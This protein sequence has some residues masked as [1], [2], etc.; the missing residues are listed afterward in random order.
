MKN[1]LIAAIGIGILLLTGGCSGIGGIRS[2]DPPSP[3]A[4]P[5]TEEDA[6]EVETVRPPTPTADTAA[7]GMVA[8]YKGDCYTETAY[9][10]SGKPLIIKSEWRTDEPSKAVLVPRASAWQ[11]SQAFCST[12]VGKPVSNTEALTLHQGE[13]VVEVHLGE[14]NHETGYDKDGNHIVIRSTWVKDNPEN[15]TM[16][17][18]GD[19]WMYSQAFCNTLVGRHIPRS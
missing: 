9:D 6:V 16:A 19:A 14:C 11:Y 3:A 18:Q 15:A 4:S 8:V 10:K 17:K 12:L 1:T 13:E 5:A 7:V 2:D